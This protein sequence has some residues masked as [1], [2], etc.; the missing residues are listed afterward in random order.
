MSTTFVEG[1]PSR[2]NPATT[3]LLSI[4]GANKHFGGLHA[5]KDLSFDIMP[6]EVLGLMGPNGAGKTTLINLIYGVHKPDTGTIKFKG[7]SIIGLS[8]HAICHLGIARTYQ[9]PQP[10]GNLTALQNIMVA[11][12]YGR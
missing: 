7:N 9:I 1:T 12:I 3:P 11:G 2:S 6:N 8:P 10:F 4:V 5:I